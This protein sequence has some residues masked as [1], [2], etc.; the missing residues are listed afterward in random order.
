MTVRRYF[1]ASYPAQG[2]RIGSRN[3]TVIKLMSAN[4]SFCLCHSGLRCVY[5]YVSTREPSG[6]A[7]DV[8]GFPSVASTVSRGDPS[9][10]LALISGAVESHRVLMREDQGSAAR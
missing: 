2:T 4:V 8:A 7:R 1:S 9:L 6:S 3:P 5:A 10:T